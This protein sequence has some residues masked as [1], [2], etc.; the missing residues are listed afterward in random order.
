MAGSSP[1]ARYSDEKKLGQCR[2]HEDQDGR[3]AM[4]EETAGGL[5]HKAGGIGHICVGGALEDPLQCA[6]EDNEISRVDEFA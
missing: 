2:R 4:P 3:L 1:A 5:A 6:I